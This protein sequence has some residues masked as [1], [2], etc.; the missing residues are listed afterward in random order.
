ME[1]T[2]KVYLFSKQRQNLEHN[3]VNFVNTITDIHKMVKNVC[4]VVLLKKS[5]RLLVQVNKCEGRVLADNKMTLR[6]IAHESFVLCNLE[7]V[8]QTY[9]SEFNELLQLLL[10]Y[11][12]PGN[13]K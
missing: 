3:I 4:F 10:C 2:E 7:R 9:C 13:F 6:D 11:K 8:Y 1:L 5:K 12:K